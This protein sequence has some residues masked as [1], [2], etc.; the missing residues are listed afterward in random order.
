MSNTVQTII[1]A[2]NIVALGNITID[3]AMVG[4]FITQKV[5]RILESRKVAQITQRGN[6]VI[7]TDSRD[8][9]IVQRNPGTLVRL[10]IS[11]V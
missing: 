8:R 4:D 9:V 7:L 2:D 10:A 1:G 3:D 11:A 5:G 6:L